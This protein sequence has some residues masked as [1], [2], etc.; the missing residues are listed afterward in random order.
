MP[1]DFIVFGQPQ[2]SDEEISEVVLTLKSNWIGTGPRVKKFEQLFAE[3]KT[4]KYAIALNSC[5]A[6]LHLS[7]LA[8]G[9]G[10]GDEVIT[11]DMTFCATLNAVI[12]SG[13]TPVLVDCFADTFN[14]NPQELETKI[15]SKTKAVI[16]VHFAGRM[17]D[18]DSI[19]SLCK[20]HGL[21]LIED[22][23]HAIESEY[24]GKMSGTFG[25]FGAFSFY[26]T[27][28]MTTGEGG[29]ITTDNQEMADK[30]KIL[31]LHG[32]SK[33]AWNRFSDEGYKHYQVVAPGFKYNMMDI[34][35]AMGIHQLKKLER[36]W[37]RRREIWEFYNR[38]L[39]DLPLTL[40][41]DAE[42]KTKHAY[43]LYTPLLQ[44]EHVR[45][46][47]DQL[48]QALCEKKIGAGVHYMAL[49]RHLYYQKALGIS[50]QQF[51][52]AE[53]ISDRTFSI[54]LSPY[55]SDDQIDYVAASLK[56]ILLRSLRPSKA[57]C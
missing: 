35:A 9:I 5:T 18:M 15:T 32:M 53:F 25:V 38:Q 7:L 31:A 24:H 26:V 23:A 51:P 27:K 1:S 34:Q 36:H 47:R 6:G 10:P 43:H 56:K 52:H 33:D 3:Y 45:L 13:A 42:K 28:N 17:C 57:V 55:L 12:H 19:Q 14:I 41:L 54:P 11:T 30:I 29:M 22:C 46:T 50:A 44:L 37:I 39:Q 49:H 8:A 2:L 48:L 20:K 16:V 40:P 21:I 4:T